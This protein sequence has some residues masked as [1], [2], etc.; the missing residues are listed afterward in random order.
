MFIYFFVPTIFSRVSSQFYIIKEK[1]ES[2]HLFFASPSEFPYTNA[3]SILACVVLWYYIPRIADK[4]AASKMDAMVITVGIGCRC[5]P[6]Q[7]LTRAPHPIYD[8]FMRQY[9]R[10]TR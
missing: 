2:G 3:S 7:L 8:D 10:H 6:W 9:A 5:V 1:Y 4:I